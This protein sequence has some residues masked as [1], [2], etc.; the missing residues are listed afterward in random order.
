MYKSYKQLGRVVAVGGAGLL[1]E[2]LPV[3]Y[4]QR[5]NDRKSYASLILAERV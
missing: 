4:V 3:Q 5:L 2:N 1:T